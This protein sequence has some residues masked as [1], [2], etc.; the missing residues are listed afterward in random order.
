MNNKYNFDIVVL[1][2]DEIRNRLTDQ[3][4]IEY[5]LGQELVFGKK[6]HSPFRDDKNPSLS[7]LGFGNGTVFWRDWGNPHVDKAQD[8]FSFVEKIFNCT[9]PEALAYINRDFGLGLDAPHRLLT[10]NTRSIDIP[11]VRKVEI[12]ADSNKIIEVENRVFSASDLSY[13]MD[14]GIFIRTL[15]KYQVFPVR[16]VW[17]DKIL[18]RRSTE[19]NPVFAYLLLNP[20][21]MENK[22]KIYSPMAATKHKWL[23]NASSDVI[24][25]L[26]QLS[27]SRSNL[28]ITKSLKDVMVLD[29]LGFD[30]VAPQSE[31]TPIS[32]AAMADFKRY[33]GS[34][35]IAFYDNDEA[36]MIT[37][38]NL[39]RTHRIK[40]MYL[41]EDTNVK[42]ISDYVKEYGIIKAE[43][44]VGL[45][46]EKAKYIN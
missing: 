44:L 29:S 39:A 45:L 41:D 46:I 9:F 11:K 13:S 7:F 37:S 14:Y 28:I 8:V 15:V 2:K 3:Q 5:Y 10:E 33:Y 1:N 17:I 43:K 20:I 22:Y 23:T 38:A 24:Q 27:Y 32:L 12:K 26:E 18:V 35:I 30:A 19:S 42:D 34:N 16:Y 21:V 6:Y 25:G 31:G 40:R 4:I 36:G